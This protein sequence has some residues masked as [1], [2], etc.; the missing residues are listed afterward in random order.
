MNASRRAGFTLIEL[1]VVIAIIAILIGL[2]LPALGKA[3]QAGYTV[4]CLSN[5]KQ[6]GLAA[7]GYAM[8]YKDEIW[9]V[10]PRVSYPDG[11]RMWNPTNDPTIEP[12]DRNVAMWAQI[13]PG[14][15]W[16]PWDPNV[17][18]RQPGFLFQYCANAHEIAACPSNKRRA[19]NGQEHANLWASRTGVQFDYTMLDETEGVKL[20]WPGQVG[21]LPANA[22]ARPRILTMSM[23]DSLTL[24][25]SLP[26][27]FEE[28]VYVYNQQYRDGMFGNMDQLTTRHDG[29]GHVAYV[30]G[31][32]ER[33]KLPN[34]NRESLQDGNADF[35]CN[36]LYVNVKGLKTTWYAISDE[37]DRFGFN[38]NYG[39]LNAPR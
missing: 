5:M 33:L 37:Y 39:W 15:R 18:Y 21:Y 1:L 29:G 38:Q 13:V 22:G 23:A 27:F 11:L 25:R 8:D 26:I 14:P 30:D 7:T 36:D 16:N 35:E 34:D 24:L 28:S 9:P 4:K 19:A 10:E 32:C 17:G 31:S 2:L 6:F 12:D 20:G 3:R